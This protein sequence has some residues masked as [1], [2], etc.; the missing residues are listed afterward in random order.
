M[1]VAFPVALVV[2]AAALLVTVLSGSDEEPVAAAP[3]APPSPSV[4]PLLPPEDPSAKA[5]PFRVVLRWTGVDPTVGDDGYEV[6]RDGTWIGDVGVGETRFVDDEAIPG[7]SLTYEIRTQSL[8]GRYSEPVSIEVSTPLPPV[9]EARVAGVFDVRGDVTSV[10]GITGYGDPTFGW[11]MTPDCDTRACGT[12][13]RDR[14]NDITIELERKGGTYTASFTD[15][16]GITCGGTPVTSSGTVVLHVKKAKV[17]GR[18]WRA[19]RLV[20]TMTHSE[21]AQLGC[22]SSG[23]TLAVNGRLLQ[24]G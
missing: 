10:Y 6:R 17:I 14:V 15:R 8:D 18:E 19:T 5:R 3:S 13:L 23:A 9:S 21:S 22:R 20:G 7:R 16:L 1:W 2:L 11:R 12:R 24:L 4:E